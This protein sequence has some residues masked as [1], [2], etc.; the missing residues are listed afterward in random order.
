MVF[1]FTLSFHS[2]RAGSRLQRRFWHFDHTA[3]ISRHSNSGNDNNYTSRVFRITEGRRPGETTAP[4]RDDKPATCGERRRISHNA[5]GRRG[6]GLNPAGGGASPAGGCRAR[7][8]SFGNMISCGNSDVMTVCLSRVH[9]HSHTHTHTHSVGANQLSSL[10]MSLTQPPVSTGSISP[11]LFLEQSSS[12]RVHLRRWN[13]PE[14]SVIHQTN[15]VLRS[16][17]VTVS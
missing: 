5:L 9:T 11:Q 2:F 12:T 3:L 15:R 8:Q 16:C 6:A 7:N 10:L 14:K 17:D 4:N 1:N 13:Q